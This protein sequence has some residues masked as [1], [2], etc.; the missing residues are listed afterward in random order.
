MAE[1][2]LA[3][4]ETQ[5]NA[6]SSPMTEPDGRDR[7]SAL[8][9]IVETAVSV[10]FSVDVNRMRSGT[11][12]EAPVAQARQ[13]AMYLAHCS[14]GMSCT[15]VGRMFRRDRTTVGHA[16]TIIEDRRDDPRFDRTITNLEEIIGRLT[17]ISAH[18]QE[19]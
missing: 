12:G 5:I 15:E 14:L 16:C 17:K 18:T 1:M 3:L 8:T 7:A 19:N 2:V 10:V 6:S 13:V 4:I 11:R 9:S